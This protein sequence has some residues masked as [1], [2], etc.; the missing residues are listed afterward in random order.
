MHHIQHHSNENQKLS[1]STI[2]GQ[3]AKRHTTPVGN[4]QSVTKGGLLEYCARA[5]SNRQSK[6][7]ATTPT[8]EPPPSA[9]SHIRSGRLRH[10]S[11][12]IRL[13][14]KT[15]TREPLRHTAHPAT[16]R[17]RSTAA[18]CVAGAHPA[19][20]TTQQAPGR[21]R[22][23]GNKEGQTRPSPERGGGHRRMSW[24]NKWHYDNK[25]VVRKCTQKCSSQTFFA[26]C[27]TWS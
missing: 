10:S 21:Q 9:D 11:K 13:Q 12:P 27:Y 3:H 6:E 5:T 7:R 18:E 24:T 8:R 25:G 26:W 16:A 14:S 20:A 23:L 15:S 2:A 22:R 4:R 1:N 19:G 17:G